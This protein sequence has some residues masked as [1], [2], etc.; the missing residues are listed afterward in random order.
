MARSFGAAVLVPGGAGSRRRARVRREADGGAGRLAKQS[1]PAPQA[2]TTGPR[3]PLDH[4]CFLSKNCSSSVDPFNAPVDASRSIVVVTA[5]K[6][7]V[8]TSR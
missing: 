6:Y 7:P 2:G 8:P 3:N 4:A 1:R 5:S